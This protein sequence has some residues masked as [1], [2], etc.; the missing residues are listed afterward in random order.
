M[1]NFVMT[2]QRDG[3]PVW[4]KSRADLKSDP[5]RGAETISSPHN[6]RASSCCANSYGG[7]IASIFPATAAQQRVATAKKQASFLGGSLKNVNLCCEKGESM[8]FLAINSRSGMRGSRLA[9]GLFASSTCARRAMATAKCSAYLNSKRIARQ[10][11][12]R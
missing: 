1:G 11:I 8:R 12:S 2:K 9:G 7:G 5:C 10:G 6:S 3:Q 4:I